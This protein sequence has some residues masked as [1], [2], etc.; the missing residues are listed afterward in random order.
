M[1]SDWR[2]PG[3][4][5]G[6]TQRIVLVRHGET[7][8]SAKGHCYGKLD[9]PLSER[10]R[11]QMADTAGL[12]APLQPAAVISSPRIRAH[13]SAVII[14]RTCSLTVSI[15]EA[16]AELDFGDFEGLKYEDVKAKHPDFYARW[17]AHP[18]E[19]T[20]PN[21]ESYTAMAERVCYGYEA[22][23]ASGTDNVRVLVAHGG[24]IRIILAS[25]L[26][27]QPEHVFRLDQSYSAV[28]CIDY[29]ENTPV[30]RVMNWL[31]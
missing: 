19:V 26:S 6:V 24:V 28:T 13:D 3:T 15:N 17:M 10:G 16:F 25:V 11:L 14:A 5:P 2:Q 4:P 1:S 31:P 27:L 20:F 9:V 29:Y 30:I 23:L 7:D 8:A 21:G 18:T 22:L 12:L